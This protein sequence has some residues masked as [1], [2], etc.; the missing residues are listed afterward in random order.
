MKVYTA[1][2]DSHGNVIVCGDTRPRN[3]YRIIHTGTYQECLRY[4]LG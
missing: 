3:G 4:K 2:R 1:Q